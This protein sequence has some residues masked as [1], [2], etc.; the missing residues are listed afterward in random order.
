MKLLCLYQVMFQYRV[1]TFDAISKLPNI[2]FELWHGSSVQNSK[3]KNYEGV[4]SFQQRQLPTIRLKGRTNNGDVSFAYYPFLLFRL[5]IKNPDVILT[6]GAS[7]IIASSI[8]FVYCKLFHKRI[9]WW[10]LGALSGRTSSGLSKIVHNWIR[11]I[12]RHCDA[13]FAYSTQAENYFLSIGVKKDKIFKAINVIDINSKLGELKQSVAI[14]KM[15]GFHIAYVGAITKYKKIEMLLDVV[16]E[17]SKKYDDIYLH[18]IG[19]GEYI[20]E[21]KSFGYKNASCCNVIYHGRI[22]NGLNNLLQQFSVLVLPGLGGLAIVDGMVSS[23]PVI[24][25]SADGT[26]R[27]LI[28]DGENGFVTDN[29]TKEYLLDKISYLYNHPNELKRMGKSSFDRITGDYS[30]DNYILKFESCL[31]SV[32]YEE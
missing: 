7:S 1:G 21:I 30:F 24:A 31:K 20:K 12:E 16:N 3:L 6:E 9:I 25:G 27:D 32:G 15:S 2:D 26:E 10:S 22:T 19:D 13:I 4:V 29:M 8:A 11:I 18:I 14:Q 23:L 28:S 17:L 5:I